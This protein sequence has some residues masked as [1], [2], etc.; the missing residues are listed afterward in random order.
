MHIR[1]VICA[2]TMLT[3]AIALFRPNPAHAL[4]GGIPSLLNIGRRWPAAGDEHRC[5]EIT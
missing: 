2:E 3:Q 1:Y 5:T 4:D